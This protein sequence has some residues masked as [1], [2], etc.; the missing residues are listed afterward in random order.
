MYCVGEEKKCKF[1][2]VFFK[3]W[4]IGITM[5]TNNGMLH[6]CSDPKVRGFNSR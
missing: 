4:S 1:R 5:C 2:Q 3:P 6:Y